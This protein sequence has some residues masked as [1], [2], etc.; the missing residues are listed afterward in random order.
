MKEYTSTNEAIQNCIENRY[1]AI[2]HIHDEEMSLEMQ[3]TD[4]YQIYFS[5]LGD[6]QFIIDEKAYMVNQGDL[7]IINQYEPYHVMH[8][9][10]K[11]H[12]SYVLMIHPD[13]IKSLSSSETDLDYCFHGK[14]NGFDNRISL[15]F[16]H[17]SAILESIK[18]IVSC[19][20]YGHDL[21][22][23]AAF[24]ELLVLINS[25]VQE[26][27]ETDTSRNGTGNSQVN[28]MMSLINKNIKSTVSIAYLSQEFYISES[29]VCRV[30]KS[31]CGTTINK[32]MTA[33]KISIAKALLAE[34]YGVREACEESGFTD[35]SNFLKAF[36]KLVGISPKKYSQ[37]VLSN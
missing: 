3:L 15:S 33:R 20:G 6:K 4:C 34:G 17:Q 25:I 2:A 5:I 30:F 18:K 35:Y 31:T 21:I 8:H 11:L 24:I 26:P 29:Y 9:P 28:S 14:T 19:D 23:K 37:Q 12:E 7:Y 32:Y 16:E 1:F 13:F 10:K 27:L 36:T 22:E